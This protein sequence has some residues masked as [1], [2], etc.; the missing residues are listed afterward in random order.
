M[1]KLERVK[2]DS[3]SRIVLPQH[4]REMLN[5]SENTTAYAALKGRTRRARRCKQS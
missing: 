5:L 1:S 2:I 4:F 3:R